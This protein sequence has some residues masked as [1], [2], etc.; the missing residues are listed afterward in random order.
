MPWSA[1]SRLSPWIEHLVLSYGGQEDNKEDSGGSSSTGQL[2]AHVIG[3]GQMTQSQARGSDGPTGLL[4]LSDG[5]IQI[6][7]I[8][9]KSAWEH[10]QEQEE[11]ECFSSLLNSTVYI[12]DYWL[13]FHMAREQTK[14]RFFLLVGKLA[15]VAVGP[16]KHITPC[17]TSLPSVRTKICRT[18]RDLLGQ[19][20][21]QR[22]QCGF[23]LSELLGEWQHDCLQ[24]VLEDVRQRLVSVQPSTS[25]CS[26]SATPA[27]TGWDADRIKYKGEE[28]FSIPVRCLLIPQEKQ[29]QMCVDAESNSKMESPQASK[30]SETAQPSVEDTQCNLAEP[31]AAERVDEASESSP[32]LVE[33]LKSTFSGLND[34]PLSNPWD[35]FPPPSVTSSY[36]DVSSS[37]SPHTAAPAESTSDPSNLPPYQKQPST[38]SATNRS[39]SAPSA[40]DELHAVTTEQDLSSSKQQFE[41]AEVILRKYS[42]AKRKR[43]DPSVE[44][45]ASFAGEKELSSSPPSWLFESPTRVGTD[46]GSSPGPAVESV[47]RTTPSVHSDGKP[48]S[49]SYQMFGQNL[50]DFS[51]FVVP[52]SLLR[53]A[54]KYLVGPKPTDNPAN[55]V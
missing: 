47:P 42:K 45:F 7:A 2:K 46:D 40:S 38:F 10:L 34:R 41:D 3:V 9:T 50:Q 37:T 39:S 49:Y 5:E 32:L 43:S 4:F 30:P 23:E 17:C 24:A 22:S 14:C 19:E 36:S 48:F 20:D 11:R 8:L 21:S 35:V 54:V 12:K 27:A 51:R 33:L 15:T 16:T 29:P 6:P 13:K 31:A 25:A 53:W 52:E 1:R 26:S 44:A 28:G 55:V 18:W